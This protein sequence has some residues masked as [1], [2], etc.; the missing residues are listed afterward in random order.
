MHSTLNTTYLSSQGINVLFT[1]AG[2]I[3]LDGGFTKIYLTND[4][5]LA[6]VQTGDSTKLG[7]H[8]TQGNAVNLYEYYNHTTSP[9]L[10]LYFH[11]TPSSPLFNIGPRSNFSIFPT[12][13]SATNLTVEKCQIPLPTVTSDPPVLS[14]NSSGFNTLNKLTLA[15]SWPTPYSRKT[16][17]LQLRNDTSPLNCTIPALSRTAPSDCSEIQSIT[18]DWLTATSEGCFYRTATVGSDIQT[19]LQYSGVLRLTSEEFPVTNGISYPRSLEYDFRINILFTEFA[20][21]IGTIT[22]L[23]PVD[24]EVT[25]VGQVHKNTADPPTTYVYIV[26]QIGYPFKLRDFFV[27]NWIIYPSGENNNLTT[28]S[29]AEADLTSLGYPESDATQAGDT[30]TQTWQLQVVPG[31]GACQ[32]DGIYNGTNVLQISCVD[33]SSTDCDPPVSTGVTMSLSLSSE[34]FCGQ[35]VD[36]IGVNLFLLPTDK[37]YTEGATTLLIAPN[38][39]SYW[40]LGLSQP[41]STG[42]SVTSIQVDQVLVSTPGMNPQPLAV[43]IS[44]DVTLNFQATTSANGLEVYFSFDTSDNTIFNV[45][46]NSKATMTVNARAQIQYTGTASKKRSIEQLPGA[47]STSSQVLASVG[48]FAVIPSGSTLLS[49][50]LG[51]LMSLVVVLFYCLFR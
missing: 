4:S 2:W 23:A 27:D 37:N 32:V 18:L 39:K 19:K 35:V 47:S 8:I 34:N 45:Q 41:P 21:V 3:K 17:V 48:I 14:L 11:G 33:L 22:M 49:P 29:L 9:S 38:A 30:S 12:N 51:G 15:W 13:F 24:I 6:G 43:L 16:P 31:A 50:P 1:S 40:K 36:D 42:V 10:V 7:I 28:A 20:E 44:N 46:P 5:S 26:T 25:I